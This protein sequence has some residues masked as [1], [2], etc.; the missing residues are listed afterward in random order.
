MLITLSSKN[1]SNNAR[2]TNYFNDTITIPKDAFI[3]LISASIVTQDGETLI[4]VPADQGLYILWDI[5]N[6]VDYPLPTGTFTLSQFV[7]TFN[8]S[9]DTTG[10]HAIW[11]PKMEDDNDESITLNFNRRNNTRLITQEIPWFYEFGYWP[12]MLEAWETYV[13]SHSYWRGTTSPG[14]ALPTISKPTPSLGADVSA[15]GFMGDGAAYEMVSHYSGAT[16][17]FGT[18]EF[19]QFLIGD[20]ANGNNPLTHN[21]GDF[22]GMFYFNTDA[23]QQATITLSNNAYVNGTAN[24]EKELG[25]RKTYYDFKVNK[26][27]DIHI[28]RESGADDIVA[29]DIEYEPG[30]LFMTRTIGRDMTEPYGNGLGLSFSKYTNGGLLLWIPYDPIGSTGTLQYNEGDGYGT[31]TNYNGNNINLYMGDG[32]NV[33]QE[34]LYKFVFDTGSNKLGWRAGSGDNRISGGFRATNGDYI[35]DEFIADGVNAVQIERNSRMPNAGMIKFNRNT[36]QRHSLF[37]RSGNQLFTGKTESINTDLPTIIMFGFRLENDGTDGHCILGHGGGGSQQTLELSTSGGGTQ[38]QF[39]NSANVVTNTKFSTINIDA[40]TDY[41]FAIATHGDYTDTGTHKIKCYVMTAA[42]V[43]HSVVEDAAVKDLALIQC[44]GGKLPAPTGDDSQYMNGNIWDFRVYQHSE[45]A[46]VAGTT[47]WDNLFTSIANYTINSNTT[48]THADWPDAWY[49]R[50]IRTQL[51]TPTA[52][53]NNDWNMRPFNTTD[54]YLNWLV[55]RPAVGNSSGN[56]WFDF[57]NM[58]YSSVASTFHNKRTAVLNQDSARA[59]QLAATTKSLV[60][61]AAADSNTSKNTL[62]LYIDENGNTHDY[63]LANRLINLAY[64]NHGVVQTI[65][66]EEEIA[67]A[68]ADNIR[69]INIENLPQRAL[70]GNRHTISKTIYQLPSV[71]DWDPVGDSQKKSLVVPSRVHIPLN[72]LEEF[73]VNSLEVRITTEEGVDD[74]S[75]DGT[76]NIVVEIGKR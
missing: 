7:D 20:I 31:A 41:Y 29:G 26:K 61:G 33:T 64:D 53:T 34:N 65:V 42:G 4:T 28:I 46:Q 40:D 35:L 37:E 6:I 38:V 74:T 10:S 47:Y 12:T 14:S 72:N 66:G 75:L 54:R 11:I 49:N 43:V 1:E 19:T 22:M 21:W 63:R 76:S 68:G 52:A 30:D 2:F 15:T 48:P 8:S 5:Y 39:W 50:M 51:W 27:V 3:S 59:F 71:M 13:N 58:N 70:D 73:P 67:F 69:N 62:K 23:H 25:E 57:M 36:H 32:A 16:G 44:I 18:N 17:M 56:T 24:Y 55:E 9:I 60:N 45:Y